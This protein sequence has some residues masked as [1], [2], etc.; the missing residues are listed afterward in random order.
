MQIEELANYVQFVG[1]TITNNINFV[2]SIIGFAL[3]VTILSI[4]SNFRFSILGIFP[5]KLWSVGGIICSPFLHGSF[6]HW[7]FNAIPFFFLSNFVIVEFGRN[8]FISIS[9]KIIILSNILTWVFGR[10]GV[11]IGGSGVI[12][13]Y[14]GFLLANVIKT[15]SPLA[16]G[17]GIATLYYFGTILFSWFPSEEKT[18][19]ESHLFG[20]ITGFIIAVY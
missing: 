13:G 18:S 10:K 7:L 20:L 19:W 16:I 4:L 14:F 2:G 1:L 3:I 8:G 11:H 15:P 5:R 12:A 17:L 6:M 9:A